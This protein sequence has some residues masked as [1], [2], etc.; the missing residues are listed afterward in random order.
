MSTMLNSAE[1][2]VDKVEY[3]PKGFLESFSKHLPRL[4]KVTKGYYGEEQI[5]TFEIGQVIY[6]LFS[7]II[8]ENTSYMVVVLKL[9]FHTFKAITVHNIFFRLLFGS[10]CMFLKYYLRCKALKYI[11]L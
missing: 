4:V 9:G 1:F 2:I 8:D 10:F 3:S 6:G 7:F 11:S 5:K